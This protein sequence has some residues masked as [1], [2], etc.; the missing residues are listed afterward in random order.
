MAHTITTQQREN[1]IQPPTTTT[2]EWLE[3]LIDR[4]LYAKEIFLSVA[5]KFIHETHLDV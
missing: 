3:Q 4:C 2:P 5:S 1:R